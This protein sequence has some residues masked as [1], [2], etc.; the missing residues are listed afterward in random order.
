[1]PLFRVY[2][3]I[4]DDIVSGKKTIEVRNTEING[5][6]ATF[7]CGKEMTRKQITKKVEFNIHDTFIDEYWSKILPSA[8]D[9]QEVRHRIHKLYPNDGILYAYFLGEMKTLTDF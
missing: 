7:Q 5:V 9:S 2:K 6:Y 1:M 4:Y 3:D 8:K